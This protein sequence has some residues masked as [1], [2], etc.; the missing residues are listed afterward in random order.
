MTL[1]PLIG[2]GFYSP[3][4][5][6]EAKVEF[7]QRYWRKCLKDRPVVIV[8]NSELGLPR[9]VASDKDQ[10]IRVSYNLG[11][12][13][14]KLGEN[15]PHLKGWSMSWILPALIAY[16]SGR[17]FFYVE[18]DALVF[19]DWDKHIYAEAERNRWLAAFGAGTVMACEQSLFFIKAEAISRFVSAYMA[20]TDG[21]S[22]MLPE[23]KFAQMKRADSRIGIHNLG[24]GRGRPI[25]PYAPAWYF[26]QPA[27]F[28][29][30]LLEQNKLI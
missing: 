25:T 9:A 17:D 2:T 23:A 24:V 10:I 11:H 22:V 8:D 13:C 12:A 6:H 20:I 7:F 3:E 1:P 28:E 5:Y 19:G 16:S 4:L 15:E 29:L 26:Q 21:D 18:Q 27:A 30:L 14:D